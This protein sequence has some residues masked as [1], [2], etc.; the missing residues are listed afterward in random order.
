MII[1]AVVGIRS[2]V[3]LASVVGGI[4]TLVVFVSVWEIFV[5]PTGRWKT[6]HYH[7]DYPDEGVYEVGVAPSAGRY[8]IARQLKLAPPTPTVRFYPVDDLM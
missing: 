1:M 7:P 2:A 5:T 3:L 6:H 8:W 4:V